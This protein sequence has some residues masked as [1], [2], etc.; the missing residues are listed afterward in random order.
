MRIL[1]GLLIAAITILIVMSFLALIVVHWTL[2]QQAFSFKPKWI[3]IYLSAL[4]RY[5]A[6]FN[7]TVATI[8]AYFGFHTLNASTDA[9]VQTLKQWSVTELKSV[10]N[11]Q[12]TRV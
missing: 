9:N 4:S 12:F 5:K 8:A 11:L 3:E 2:S 7:A 10:L 6:L 1:K